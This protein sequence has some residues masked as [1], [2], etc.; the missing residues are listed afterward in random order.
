MEAEGLDGLGEGFL[1]RQNVQS[2]VESLWSDKWR[3]F[4]QRLAIGQFILVAN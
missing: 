1:K 4:Q 2:E 3:S